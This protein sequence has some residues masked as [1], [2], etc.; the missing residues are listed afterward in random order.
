MA[1]N[2]SHI[3]SL[4]DE[5]RALVNTETAAYHLNRKPKTLRSWASGS[6]GPI[7]PQRINGRLAWPVADL[8]RLVQ[9]VTA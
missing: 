1:A 9:G 5:N 7:T 3:P 6:G 4:S 8:R 2:I